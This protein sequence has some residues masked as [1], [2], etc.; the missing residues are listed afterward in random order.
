MKQFLA[1]LALVLLSVPLSGQLTS[2]YVQMATVVVMPTHPSATDTGNP[3]GSIYQPRLTI[4]N[5]VPAGTV[6][7]LIGPYPTMHMSPNGLK[8]NG[9][10]AA[11]VRIRSAIPSSPAILSGSWEISATYATFED[12]RWTA[13]VNFVAPNNQVVLRDSQA[14]GNGATCLGIGINSYSA[15]VNTN[16]SFYR[17][18]SSDQ[19]DL[20][21]P[22]D[23][24]C[25]GLNIGHRSDHIWIQESLFARNSG[26][27]IQING[28]ADGRASTHHIMVSGSTAAFNKQAGFWVKQA[29]DVMFY[30]NESHD[31]RPSNSSPGNCMG[32][33]YGPE[34]VWWVG[35]HVYNCDYG[36]QLASN[37][38]VGD[39]LNTIFIANIVHDIHQSVGTFDPS[40]PWQSCGLSLMGGSKR[41]V[42]YTSLYN[43]DSGICTTGP[44]TLFEGGSGVGGLRPGGVAVFGPLSPV[45]PVAQL[46]TLRQW[47]AARGT[48]AF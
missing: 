28:T 43:V 41:T 15:A 24:D 3:L 37:S 44:T 6:V 8:V 17:V 20:R 34:Y 1:F 40:N 42:L 5:P 38:G 29:T 10:A 30:R 25:H 19:G 13:G 45:D 18:T 23:Q 16:I 33:Q 2:P 22:I 26:D 31:H 12:L 11:P 46:Q 7:D 32:G 35:N 9:S 27:G 36:I 39:G 4:P 21:T 14:I 47:S 48:G